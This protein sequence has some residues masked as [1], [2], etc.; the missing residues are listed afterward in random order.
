MTDLKMHWRLIQESDGKTHLTIQWEAGHSGLMR[1]FFAGTQI[2]RSAKSY[3]QLQSA[4]VVQSLGSL[5]S[6]E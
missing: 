6:Y 3:A 4:R 5:Q 1:D 2:H